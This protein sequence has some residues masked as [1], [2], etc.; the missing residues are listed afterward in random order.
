MNDAARDY[1][2]YFWQGRRVR[3]RP[4]RLDDAE[5]VAIDRLDTPSRQVLQL[6]IELPTSVEAVREWLADHAGCKDKEGL[7]LFAVETLEGEY[8]GGMSWHSRNVKNGTFGFAVVI[9]REHRGRGYG[10]EAVRLLLRYAFHEQ[11][12]QKCNSA[13]LVTNEASLAMHR[14]LG[15]VEEGVR[16]RDTFSHGTYYDLQLFGMTREEFDATESP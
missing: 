2:R 12:Y 14:R 10:A 16:R 6:G 7:V 8:V 4:L 11:R 5:N 13:C 3:V 9:R 1:S 15:F